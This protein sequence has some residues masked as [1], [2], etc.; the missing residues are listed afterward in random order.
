[1]PICRAFCNN[2]INS[3]NPIRF[4]YY[5]VA[6]VVLQQEGGHPSTTYCDRKDDRLYFKI[7]V[8][9]RL[10]TICNEVLL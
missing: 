5:I 2:F 3:H 7:Y 1:M 6:T 4:S 9:L 10:Y 8:R